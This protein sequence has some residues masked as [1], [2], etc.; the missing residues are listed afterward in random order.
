MRRKPERDGYHAASTRHF[1]V[2]CSGD[3]VFNHVLIANL[4]ELRVE[5]IESVW[6]VELRR[7]LT[8]QEIIKLCSGKLPK[9]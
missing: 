7:E 8:R 5:I 3:I 1:N 4:K 2:R 6:C 9:E